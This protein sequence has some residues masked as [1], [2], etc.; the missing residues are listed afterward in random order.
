VLEVSRDNIFD[1]KIINN[2]YER[3]WFGDMFPSAWGVF[4]F[5]LS[6]G[7][8]TFAEEIIGNAPSLR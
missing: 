4:G 8:K 2:E 5:V 1:A 7:M 3:D 6:I